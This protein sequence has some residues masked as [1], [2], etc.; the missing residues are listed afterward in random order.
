MIIIFCHI[1]IISMSYQDLKGSKPLHW[2][3]KPTCM[4]TI[5]FTT[6]TIKKT[7]MCCC[8]PTPLS[9]EC[10]VTPLSSPKMG[11]VEYGFSQ[12]QNND[13]LA[14]PQLWNAKAER[15]SITCGRI[16]VVVSFPEHSSLQPA[17]TVCV[18]V[19]SLL[20]VFD[21]ASQCTFA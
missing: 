2:H 9:S 19:W 12:C 21:L 16:S 13:L 10:T 6:R 15:N 7:I 8:V 1:V 18:C 5:N 11:L 4:K 14:R 20:K 3:P 17:V